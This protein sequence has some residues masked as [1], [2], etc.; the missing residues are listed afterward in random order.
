MVQVAKEKNLM[1]SYWNTIWKK[2]DQIPLKGWSTSVSPWLQFNSKGFISKVIR[3]E[4]L[5]TL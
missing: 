1:M 5:K 2:G 3:S 4:T